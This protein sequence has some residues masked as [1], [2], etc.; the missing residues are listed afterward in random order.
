MCAGN[1]E[2]QQRSGVALA[3]GLWGRCRQ[4]LLFR[5]TAGNVG[6]GDTRVHASNTLIFS[7]PSV[8]LFVYI[9]WGC[10]ILYK[11]LVAISLENIIIYK[12]STS[13]ANEW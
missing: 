8:K 7:Y 2:G 12:K 1:W 3:R 4:G 10:C 11:L 6:S 13:E 9:T 5:G